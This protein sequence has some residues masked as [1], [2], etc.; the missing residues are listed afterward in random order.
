MLAQK[1]SGKTLSIQSLSRLKSR[2]N[3][4]PG[5]CRGRAEAQRQSSNIQSS[6]SF[7]LSFSFSSFPFCL[8]LGFFFF[9]APG[10]QGNLSKPE[11]TSWTE[12]NEQSHQWPYTARNKVS[13]KIVGKSHYT[14]DY[15]SPQ[16][17]IKQQAMNKRE[18]IFHWKR[19]QVG[20]NG[21]GKNTIKNEKNRENM[22]SWITV[23]VK[24]PCLKNNTMFTK[25]QGSRAYLRN[26]TN[27]QKLS[28]RKP[29]HWIS[30]TMTLKLFLKNFKRL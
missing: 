15:Y 23:I 1:T 12:A 11:P 22:F 4:S 13:A 19:V 8:S 18:D 7:C 30:C 20:L 27:R 26:T 16:Q 21:N 17:S 9:F 3:A 28:Q 6:C 10:T 25:K 5:N 14:M 2:Q 29:R 24:C